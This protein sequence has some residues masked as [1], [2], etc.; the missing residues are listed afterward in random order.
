MVRWNVS[1]DIRLD[2]YAS[3][4][5]SVWEEATIQL[6]ISCG[7]FICSDVWFGILCGCF[8][9]IGYEVFGL[10]W[11]EGIHGFEFICFTESDEFVS[12]VQSAC[13]LSVKGGSVLV[14][15]VIST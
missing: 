3:V 13:S 1:F 8:L 4:F 15:A 5:P 14:E 9:F 12:V 11:E 6:F 10:F 2:I 7:E